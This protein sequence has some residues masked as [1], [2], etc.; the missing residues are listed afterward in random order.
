M[1]GIDKDGD[2]I[3]SAAGGLVGRVGQTL[4]GMAQNMI[5]SGAQNVLL[6]GEGNDVFQKINGKYTV[7]PRRGRLRAVFIFSNTKIRLI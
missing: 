7:E 5:S 1:I 4:E 3:A 6:M 2:I